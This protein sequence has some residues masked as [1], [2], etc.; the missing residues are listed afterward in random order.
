MLR[1]LHHDAPLEAPLAWLFVVTR[2]LSNR[3]R[4]NNERRR[5]AE[6]SDHSLLTPAPRFTVFDFQLILRRLP[7][8]DRRLLELVINGATAC[9]IARVFTCHSRDVG[10]MVSR[11]R[12]KARRIRD[13]PGRPS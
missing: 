13:Q 4:L 8:R 7:P 1:L 10:Q 5:L 12:A 3:L 6:A 11:A 2:R 9:D